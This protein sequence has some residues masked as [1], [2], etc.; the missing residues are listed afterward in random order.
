MRL[1]MCG[2]LKAFRDHMFDEGPSSECDILDFV[3]I[4]LDDN[5]A[6]DIAKRAL[7][8]ADDNNDGE[9][10]RLRGVLWVPNARQLRC[11]RIRGDTPYWSRL[12]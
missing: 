12:R 7:S 8:K 4:Y 6:I 11:V 9:G 3:T 5:A 2:D 10:I 1:I